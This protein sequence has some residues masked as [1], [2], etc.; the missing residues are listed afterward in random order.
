MNRN[1]KIAC[2]AGIS[3]VA[4]LAVTSVINHHKLKPYGVT[5]GAPEATFQVPEDVSFDL[6]DARLESIGKLSF[7]SGELTDLRK[8][9]TQEALPG[10]VLDIQIPGRMA[11]LHELQKSANY[12]P[13]AQSPGHAQLG[14]EMLAT[15]PLRGQRRQYIATLSPDGKVDIQSTLAGEHRLHFSPAPGGAMVLQ[16][17]DVSPEDRDNKEPMMRQSFVSSDGGRHW[18]FDA[19]HRMPFFYD[20]Q[21]FT[22]ETD[23]FALRE[24][25]LLVTRDSGL[26]W[27]PLDLAKAVWQDA[28]AHIG[29]MQDFNWLMLTAKPGMAIGW[30]TL[31]ERPNTDVNAKSQT[32]WKQIQTRRFEL[33][34]EQGQPASVQQVV[35]VADFTLADM[36]GSRDLLRSPD[37]SATWQYKGYFLRYLN[38]AS[39]EWS[40]PMSP[41]PIGDVD[42]WIDTFWVGDGL[43]VI[44][45]RGS[46][47]RNHGDSPALSYF[48]SRDQGRSWTSFV[49]DDASSSSTPPEREVIGWDAHAQKLV[50]FH[51]QQGRSKATVELYA[52]PSVVQ[53]PPLPAT[54]ARP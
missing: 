1:K 38:P 20:Y 2:I 23:G 53:K 48:M 52:L 41:P 36:G 25:Q 5:L 24:N 19:K 14:A 18:R 17:V 37:G 46:T 33:R 42:T 22:S 40:Q 28:P 15:G 30:S 3:I 26:T 44:K 31:W 35:P 54:V 7:L 9:Y 45:A 8:P 12:A 27:R 21:G 50:V 29:V 10:A 47:I 11:A 13:A 6:A 4:A 51:R 49:L 34:F 32:A 43:W 39:W 16:S